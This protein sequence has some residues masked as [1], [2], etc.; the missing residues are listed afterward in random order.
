MAEQQSRAVRA[1]RTGRRPVP[2]T[3]ATTWKW[4]RVGERAEARLRQRLARQGELGPTEVARTVTQALPDRLGGALLRGLERLGW[5]RPDAVIPF[6]ILDGPRCPP[7][8]RG[9][10]R[11]L[12]RLAVFGLPGQ[13]LSHRDRHRQDMY[14]RLCA[15]IMSS[16]VDTTSL[17][18]VATRTMNHP[19]VS[20]DPVLASMLRSFI[21][22][23]EDAL[24][25]ERSSPAEQHNQHQHSSKL[26]SAFRGGAPCDFPSREELLATFGR[27]L[28]EFDGYL[29]Q[30][31]EAR[32][33]A[34]LDK[35][36]ELRQCFPIHIRAEDLQRCEEQYD[37]L[38][39]RAGTYRRQIDELAA[40]GTAAAQ[41]G[42]E[43]TAAWVVKR[44][45]AIHTL[46]PTLLPAQRFEKLQASISRSSDEHET[47]Q[48]ARELIEQQR[49]VA[50]KIRNLAGII[51][52]FHQ[53]SAKLPPD[54]DVYQR[55]EANYRRAVE[56][57]RGLDTDWL[58]GLVLELETLL[59]ELA[60]PTGERQ[61]QLDQFIANVRTALNRLCL[62]IR[63]RR[64]QKPPR[65]EGPGNPP[66]S[67]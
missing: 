22:Q 26:R 12:A 4:A 60:D 25:A 10:P 56:E 11:E 65:P 42:D 63:A 53:I 17:Q 54:D 43:E 15:Q 21:A 28:R 51:N 31:G 59:D 49:Q 38:L 2:H 8:L 27:L 62:E 47:R 44:L 32:A 1:T 23:R 55:A 6:D 3:G 9:Q 13:G 67:E 19:E 37:R 35:M 20:A 30:F 40:R 5:L 18:T 45:H 7:E 16:A 29:A 33:A 57:I 41:A 48:A 36:R 24:R 66:A 50:N 14:Q 34:A 52:R 39:K 61:N 64:A 46:L 58:T